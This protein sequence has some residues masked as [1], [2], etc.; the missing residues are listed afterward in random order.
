L[1]DFGSVFK[2]LLFCVLLKSNSKY[3]TIL[4]MQCEVFRLERY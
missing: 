2:I 1:K 4:P 3:T